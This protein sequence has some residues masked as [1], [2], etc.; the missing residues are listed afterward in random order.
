MPATARKQAASETHALGASTARGQF[1]VAGHVGDG[2]EEDLG[3]KAGAHAGS[4]DLDEA[5]DA[6]ADAQ[7]GRDE[8]LDPD[9]EGHYNP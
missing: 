2:G 8:G 7:R 5:H 9:I 3:Q 4:Q 1:D 6:V